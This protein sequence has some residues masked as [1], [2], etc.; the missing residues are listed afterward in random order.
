MAPKH[1]KVLFVFEDGEGTTTESVWAVPEEGGY[2][3]DN[4]PFYVRGGGLQ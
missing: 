3:I 4:I 1:V 2:R